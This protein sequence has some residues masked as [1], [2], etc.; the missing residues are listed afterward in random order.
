MGRPRVYVAGPI[1]GGRDQK[2]DVRKACVATERLIE[3]GC[4]VYTPQLSIF[5]E[6]A[7]GRTLA[8]EDWLE[9]DKPWVLVSDA[10]L[11]L[12]G[13]S[14]GA[15]LEVQWAEEA[16]IPVYYSLDALLEGFLLKRVS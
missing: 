5:L 1:T 10:V 16:G 3:A 14:P 11:R 13:D 15:D 6:F 8:W 9:Q 7:V 4:A 12:P 2:S